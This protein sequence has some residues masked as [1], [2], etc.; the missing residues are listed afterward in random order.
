MNITINNNW[1]DEQHLDLIDQAASAL[2]A[3]GIIDTE[4]YNAIFAATGNKRDEFEC[5]TSE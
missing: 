4:T 3:A 1:C 2:N 5:C